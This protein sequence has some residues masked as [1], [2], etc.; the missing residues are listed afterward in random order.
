MNWPLIVAE[1]LEALAA[2]LRRHLP[3][4]LDVPVQ[5]HAEVKASQ[6]GEAHE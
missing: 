3:V 2:V 4:A 1:M 5:V 6:R